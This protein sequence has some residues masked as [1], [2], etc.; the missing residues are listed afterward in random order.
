MRKH[1]IIVLSVAVVLS[2]LMIACQ[3]SPSAQTSISL[4]CD[5]FQKQPNMVKDVAISMGKTFTVS[6]CSNKTTG[7]SWPE[8]A[9]IGDPRV[10]EQIAYKWEPP[11]DTGKVGVAGA[12]VYTFKALQPG[13]S[14]I[15]LGYSQPWQGGQKNVSTFKANVTVK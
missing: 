5:D 2:A 13:A 11:Q 12:E 1:W 8:K 9:E 6:L 7:F 3:A 4:T 10:I 15:S 14:V